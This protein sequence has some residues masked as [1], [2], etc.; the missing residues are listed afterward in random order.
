MR[1][2]HLNAATMCP[3]SARLVNG[4][5]SLFER[6]RLVCHVLLIE[7][8]DGLALVD[9]GLGLGD[10]A[11]PERL[12]ADWRRNASPRLDRTETAFEQVRALGFARDDVRHIL[13]THLDRDHAGGLSDFPA[14]TVHVHLGEYQAAVTGEIAARKGRYISEQWRHKPKWRM[15]GKEGEDWFG[16]KGVRALGDHET[17][18]MIVPLPGHTPGHCGVAVR[19]DGS[20]LL[21]A[22]DSYYF[23]GQIEIPPAAAPFALRIFQKRADTNRDDRVANQERL[24][25]LNERHGDQITIIC[26]HDPFTFDSCCSAAKTNFATRSPPAAALR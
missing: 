23:H 13:L 20:W 9:T 2:H 14:A 11:D 21:H 5:G 17:D 15:Y 18:I 24:R 22:G 8:K 4:R 12:P 3:R 25:I 26:S 6:A 1:V 10:I 19:N 16:F 7:T